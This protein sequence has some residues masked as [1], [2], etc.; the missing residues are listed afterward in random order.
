VIGGI[1][2]SP[3]DIILRKETVKNSVFSSLKP[4]QKVDATVLK[5]LSE[6]KALVLITG[7]KVIIKS[8]FLLTEGEKLQVNLLKEEENQPLR[9]VSSSESKISG[10]LASLIKLVSKSNPFASLSKA[11]NTELLELLKSISLK[12]D[13]TDKNYL[14]R[15][16]DKSGIL[17]EQKAVDLLKQAK[18]IK[19]NQEVANILKSDIKGYVLNQLQ[20]AASQNQGT[21]KVFSEY[22]ANI[23]NFQTLNAQSSDTG[24]YLIPF[25][26][27]ANDSFTFGQ[28]LID[29][30]NSTEEKKQENKERV[31]NI[32]FLLNMSKLGALRADFSIYKKAISGAFNL[33]SKEVCDFVEAML[34]ELKERLA[35]IEYLVHNIECKVVLK[36]DLSSTSFIESFTQ[37]EDR[38]LSIIV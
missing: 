7:E 37:K 28:L 13:K 32:S 15:L 27:F 36:E 20:S 3:S 6:N 30:G 9:V 34:P 8:P 12:S 17:F 19:L 35:K 10:K 1:H 2:I 24:K 4:D 25:P 16:L 23:E 31:I 11:D 38:V 21:L 29:L 33:S 14:P 18:G 26:V 22:S 5:V